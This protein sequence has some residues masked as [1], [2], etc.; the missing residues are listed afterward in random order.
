MFDYWF[1]C[2]GFGSSG[3]SRVGVEAFGVPAKQQVTALE[4]TSSRMGRLLD[5]IEAGYQAF[6]LEV[7]GGVKGV[8]ALGDRADHLRPLPSP[9]TSATT[10]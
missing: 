8:R 2:V 10:R 3:T 5:I 6:G 4:I 1:L 9:S 7:A